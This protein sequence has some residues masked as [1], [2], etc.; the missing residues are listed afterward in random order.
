MA[1]RARD[2]HR[3][4]RRRAAA[5][6]TQRLATPLVADPVDGAPVVCFAGEATSAARYGTVGGAIE[7]G[8]REAARIL[9]SIS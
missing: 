5:D 3:V 1:S 9:K 2:G 8:R 6:V 4:V 7:S